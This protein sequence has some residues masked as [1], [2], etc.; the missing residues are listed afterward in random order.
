MTGA[1]FGGCAIALVET[2]EYSLTILGLAAR[3]GDLE[4]VE[5]LLRAGADPDSRETNPSLRPLLV[6][7]AMGEREIVGRLLRAGADPNGRAGGGVTALMAATAEGDLAMVEALLA[8]GADPALFDLDRRTA[9]DIATEEGLTE[10]ADL[11]RRS[12]APEVATAAERD[13]ETPS[14]YGETPLV[15]AIA[16]GREDQVEA[17]L[18]AGADPTNACYGQSPMEAAL[19]HGAPT[20]VVEAL[21]RAGADPNQEA[22]DLWTPLMGAA[23]DGDWELAELLLRFGADPSRRNQSGETALSIAERRGHAGFCKLLESADV[24]RAPAKRLPA[25]PGG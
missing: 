4:A 22:E 8:A 14:E 24:K 20:T 18:A 6:A 15:E 2:S 11:L 12:G 7:V 21:L 13:L 1:G 16:A 9:L 19:V 10:I 25:E 17:L 23:N 3:R 5:A